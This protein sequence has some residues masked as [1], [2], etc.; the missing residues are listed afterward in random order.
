MLFLEH[1]CEYYFFGLNDEL[2][3]SRAYI[4]CVK[5]SLCFPTCLILCKNRCVMRV[6]KKVVKQFSVRESLQN[7][8]EFNSLSFNRTFNFPVQRPSLVWG[9][10][11]QCLSLNAMINCVMVSIDS[12]LHNS[13]TCA[14][15]F[16]EALSLLIVRT[17]CYKYMPVIMVVSGFVE[18]WSRNVDLCWII[19]YTNSSDISRLVNNRHF[20]N[21]WRKYFSCCLNDIRSIAPCGH[22]GL[23]YTID[24]VTNV[25]FWDG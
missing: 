20:M 17:V 15:K 3:N 8:I 5:T 16:S 1:F 6:L 22:Y 12:V 25:V 24:V 10:V 11:I 14:D 4:K 7:D 23:V 21:C 13:Y 2:F 19:T 9:C 18:N